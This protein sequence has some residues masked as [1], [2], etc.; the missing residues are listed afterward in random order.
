MK[1]CLNADIA[2][3]AQEKLDHL[4]SA[5]EAHVSTL[6]GISWLGEAWDYLAVSS[7]ERKKDHASKTKA[8]DLDIKIEVSPKVFFDQVLKYK[9]DKRG[10]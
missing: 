5:F 7:K 9:E 2:N 4:K 10:K 1:F 6:S 3:A 8:D